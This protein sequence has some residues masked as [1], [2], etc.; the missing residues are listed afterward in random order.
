[1]LKLIYTKMYNLFHVLIVSC[2][3]V[4]MIQGQQGHPICLY[5]SNSERVGYRPVMTNSFF[6]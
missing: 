1:M 4:T 5:M 2:E 6:R 3:V